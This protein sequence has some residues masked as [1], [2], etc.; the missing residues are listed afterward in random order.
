LAVAQVSL[1]APDRI[2]V[3]GVTGPSSV[4][5][6]RPLDE[7]GLQDVEQRLHL[8]VVVGPSG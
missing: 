2:T 4:L 8:E 3:A 6:R 1:I 5:H 7:L